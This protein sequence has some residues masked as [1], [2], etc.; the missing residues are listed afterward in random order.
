MTAKP[1]FISEPLHILE[2]RATLWPARQVLESAGNS[3][4]VCDDVFCNTV[5]LIRRLCFAIRALQH[6]GGTN[7]CHQTSGDRETGRWLKCHRLTITSPTPSLL[8]TAL[9]ISVLH[10]F[11]KLR[12][13]PRSQIHLYLDF[14][15]SSCHYFT[16]FTDFTD[17]YRFLPIFTDFSDFLVGVLPG[18]LFTS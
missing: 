16:Y 17:F 1:S 4:D 2:A 7:D 12:A 5:H 8:P 9:V 15:G 6:R 18:V 3:K 11:S 10:H 14:V 13:S